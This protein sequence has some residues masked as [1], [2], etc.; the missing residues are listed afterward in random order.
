MFLIVSND[1][2]SKELEYIPKIVLLREFENCI[3]LLWDRLPEH[4]RADSEVQR[5][6][7]CLKHYNLPNLSDD[8]YELGLT[9]FETYYTLPNVNSTNNKFYFDNEEIVIPEGSYELRDIERYLKR[10]I[11]RSR[12]VKSKED[13]EFPLVIRA[14]NNTMKSE[15]KCVY[16]INF[17]KPYNIGQLLEF[18]S[19]RVLEPQQWHESDVPINIINVNI[20]R[21]ECNVTA[22]A[23][24]NKCVHTIHEFSPTVPPGYKI[25]EKPTQIIYL[26]IVVR[27]ITDLTIRVVDQDGRL[28]DFRGEE[29]TV[30]LHVRRRRR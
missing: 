29:I 11:L 10:E 13:E 20:I 19:N 18:S 1:L 4:I 23:Y 2:T 17:T 3:D 28:L 14:N 16:S 24:S 26:P 8:D 27:S 12:G 22:G 9:D 6:R 30:R 15:I 5:H 21:I 7:R 25:S